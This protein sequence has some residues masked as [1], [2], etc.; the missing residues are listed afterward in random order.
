MN[1]NGSVGAQASVGVPGC[2]VDPE[3]LKDE[4][5]SSFFTLG[6]I[7]IGAWEYLQSQNKRNLV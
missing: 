3:K 2:Q 6:C 5:R 1:T 4:S 7:D